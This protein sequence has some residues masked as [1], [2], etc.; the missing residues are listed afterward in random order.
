MEP[1]DR[2]SDP[3]REAI[4][5]AGEH[6]TQFASVTAMATQVAV[7]IRAQRQ[8]QHLAHDE[9]EA[10]TR[11][12]QHQA[13]LQAARTRW[14]PAHDP[15]WLGQAD[16]LQTAQVWGAATPY[17]EHEPTAASAMRK[18]EERLRELHPH[19]MGHYD[20]LRADGMQP[21]DAMREA[22]PFFDR[23]TDV[24]TGQP[25]PQHRA[26]TAEARDELSYSA[27][28]QLALLTD[29]DLQAL[30]PAQR[31]TRRGRDI[32]ERL[33]HDVRAAGHAELGPD[34]LRTALATVTNLPAD[35][36]PHTAT[37]AVQAAR[38]GPTQAP[39]AP[40]R[41]TAP[42]TPRYHGPQR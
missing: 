30:E 34:E 25:G 17:V 3:L 24:R 35:D 9:Q 5:T 39:P 4:H 36:F 15:Q 32:I 28:E 13:D 31:I 10:R 11:R 23:R 40:S 20:R 26:L 38:T 1:T 18:C 22:A 14:A 41:T 12:Q 29:D 42:Q 6:A 2:Y 19:A 21:A 7:Q 16:L 27:A 8:R 33:Q 37:E